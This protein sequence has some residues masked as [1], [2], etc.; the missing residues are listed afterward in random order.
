MI[1]TILYFKIQKPFLK[2]FANVAIP[3]SFICWK[4]F[5]MKLRSAGKT[6]IVDDHR[7]CHKETSLQQERTSI[8]AGHRFLSLDVGESDLIQILVNESLYRAYRWG[9][10]RCCGVPLF[11]NTVD[12][13]V[14]LIQFDVIITSCF[15]CCVHIFNHF[16]FR[17]KRLRTGLQVVAEATLPMQFIA[18]MRERR[19]LI[20]SKQR[21]LN[22]WSILLVCGRWA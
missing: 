8:S 14:A 7:D 10:H 3:F 2:D 20:I 4:F 5:M 17:R 22:S 6:N 19:H 13:L 12:W 11:R 18:K 9:P 16:L 21:C 1:C 15:V